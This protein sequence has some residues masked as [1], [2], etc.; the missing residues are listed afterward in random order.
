MFHFSCKIL[1]APSD[2]I[3]FLW[4]F[5]HLFPVLFYDWST[6]INDSFQFFEFFFRNHFL[7]GGFPFQWGWFVSQ[8]FFFFIWVFFH[9]H[10]R[11]TELQGKGEGISLTP[12]YHFHLLHRR[13][14]ISQVIIAGS[15]PLNIGSNRTQAGNLWF[16]S[17]SC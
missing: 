10:S 11:I 4:N 1:I 7:G 3:T 9:N 13:L 16:P 12:H 5:C 14:D 2:K 15:S 6:I 17:A 8:V